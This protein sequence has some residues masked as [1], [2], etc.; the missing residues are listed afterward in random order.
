M[1]LVGIIQ[2][3]TNKK[4]EC[5]TCFGKLADCPGHFGY[6]KL[7]MPVFHIGYLK[8]I[9]TTLQCICKVSPFQLFHT[10]DYKCNELSLWHSEVQKARG[11]SLRAVMV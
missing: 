6:L 11:L 10:W 4:G 5:S 3:T 2:G 9:L 8:N 7:E 1:I